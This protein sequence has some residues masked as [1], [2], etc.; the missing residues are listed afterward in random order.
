MVAFVTMGYA[1]VPLDSQ[2]NVTE[3]RPNAANVSIKIHNVH[4]FL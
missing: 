4:I 1:A 2:V 3:Q